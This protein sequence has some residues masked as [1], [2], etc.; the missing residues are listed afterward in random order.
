M[1]NFL[2]ENL[3]SFSILKGF[4]ENWRKRILNNKHLAYYLISII[5]DMV[6][7]RVLKP[8]WLVAQPTRDLAVIKQPNIIYP[9]GDPVYIHIHPDPKTKSIKYH[10]IEPRLTENRDIILS[11]VEKLLALNINEK[12]VPENVEE[13]E[14]ILYELLDKLFPKGSRIKAS[15]FNIFID[16]ETYEK[17]KYEIYCE[18]IGSSILEPM[19]RDPFIEDIHCSGK[20]PIFIHHKIFGAME[21]TIV[22]NSF[23]ELDKFVIKL[24][25]FTG[26]PVSHRSPIVDATLPDGSRINIVFGEDISQRGSNFTIRKF[27]SKPISITELIKFGTF[28]PLMAAYVWMLLEERM[29]IWISGETASGKTTTL[30]AITPFIPPSAKIVSIEE[31]PEVHVPHSNWVREVV[32][33]TGDA[34]AEEAGAVSMFQLLK[35]ALRQ[36]PT[37]IIVGEVRGREGAIAFQAMQTG[38][39]VLATFHA[40]SVS[41]LV[42]RLTGHPINIPKTYID[43]L[44]AVII[45]SAVHDPETGKYK[46]RVLSVNEV[47][48]YDPVEM[49]FNF[50]EVFNW[51]PSKDTYEFRGVGSSYLLETKIAVMK[52]ISGFEIKK[53]YE[54][55]ELRAKILDFM[56][57]LG[58]FDYYEVWQN[59]TWIHNVG[60]ENAYHKYRKMCMFKLGS[61][62]VAEKSSILRV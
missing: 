12:I 58:I 6:K 41:K 37:Y 61:Q 16:E 34:A 29:S 50:I 49:Q 25:E 32:R 3:E 27:A 11:E 52:G 1:S 7:S 54:E 45:Q 18:K 15:S 21:T 19:I 23:D 28:N 8:P 26:K 30:S 46:R 2:N 60:L 48:G 24:S 47:L 38:H 53:I 59:L 56:V 31:V 17:L 44:N 4:D 5:K 55:L 33:E 9:V 22:F 62:V 36:R 10:P 13:R 20:G 40:D 51:E 42:Q 57:K 14:K 39:P 35:A 43:N